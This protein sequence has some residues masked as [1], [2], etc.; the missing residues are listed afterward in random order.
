MNTSC[1]FGFGGMRR[2]TQKK[3]KQICLYFRM[4]FPDFF[5]VFCLPREYCSSC[6]LARDC[7]LALEANDSLRSVIYD[8]LMASR[9]SRF[10]EKS[11]RKKDHLSLFFLPLFLGQKHQTIFFYLFRMGLWLEFFNS[12]FFNHLPK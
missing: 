1:V 4:L 3:K 7:W 10:T 9:L 11:R 8:L 12:F 2:T 6:R 5:F